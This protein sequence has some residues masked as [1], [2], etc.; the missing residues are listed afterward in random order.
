MAWPWLADLT[1]RN[2]Q[3]T[4]RRLRY[5]LRFGRQLEGDL[6]AGDRATGAVGAKMGAGQPS[7]PQRGEGTEKQLDEQLAELQD[8]PQQV[9]A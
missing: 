3:V 1:P 6:A 5:A 2:G 7:P 9:M 8:P 4:A